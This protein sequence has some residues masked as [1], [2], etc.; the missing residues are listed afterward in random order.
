MQS[1][2]SYTIDFY[3][4]ACM[5]TNAF[6]ITNNIYEIRHIF[7]NFHPF[8]WIRQ[9]PDIKAEFLQFCSED[10]DFYPYLLRLKELLGE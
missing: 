4:V 2:T 10:E 6:D 1:D 9:Y 7:S 3:D 8:C 5:L